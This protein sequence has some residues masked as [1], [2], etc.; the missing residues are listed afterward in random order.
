MTS[1]L[2]S[3]DWLKN[4]RNRLQMQKIHS[5]N[6][7]TTISLYETQICKDYYYIFIEQKCVPNQIKYKFM[8]F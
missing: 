4:I 7:D 8:Q 6:A 2:L 1:L 3:C 5:I